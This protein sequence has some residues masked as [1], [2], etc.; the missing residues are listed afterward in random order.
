MKLNPQ[1]QHRKK[2]RSDRIVH[3]QNQSVSP[4]DVNILFSFLS[5]TKGLCHYELIQW[6]ARVS[7]EDD[8]CPF[9]SILI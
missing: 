5:L 9:A 8:L 7:Q 6:Q 1:H 2:G 4:F 3:L